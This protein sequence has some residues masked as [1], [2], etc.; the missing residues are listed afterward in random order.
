M[1]N[2]HVTTALGFTE[3]MLMIPFCKKPISLK[4][5]VYFLINVKLTFR[6]FYSNSDFPML[7][8][9]YDREKLFTI[10]CKISKFFSLLSL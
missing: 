1:G 7:N 8:K 4:F 6:N 5:E 10:E 3:L 9:R 2:C